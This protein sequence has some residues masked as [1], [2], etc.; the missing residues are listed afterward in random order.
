MRKSGKVRER[1]RVLTSVS[2]IE[3]GRDR[4]KEGDNKSVMIRG[5]SAMIRG[6]CVMIRV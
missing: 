3:R 6:K 2:T 4:G 5:K 1:A